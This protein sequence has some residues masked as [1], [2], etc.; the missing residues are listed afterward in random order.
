MRTLRFRE[1]A[2]FCDLSVRTVRTAHRPSGHFGR[3][4]TSVTALNRFMD[5][6]L[7]GHP[8]VKSPVDMA[9]WDVLGQVASL[10]VCTLLGGR[11]G[12]EALLEYLD[13]AA[14][15]RA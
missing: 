3:D 14:L 1:K 8:Y 4:P 15:K 2:N 11:Y 7:K 9:C 13:C 5:Y 12:D 6:N 10:P